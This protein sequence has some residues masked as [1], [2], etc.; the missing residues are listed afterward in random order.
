M[1]NFWGYSRTLCLRSKFRAKIFAQGVWEA[2]VS[3]FDV[4]VGNTGTLVD[5]PPP[6]DLLR[7]V[8]RCST[9]ALLV[10]G[11]S[12]G[13]SGM[14]GS[15]SKPLADSARNVMAKRVDAAKAAVDVSSIPPTPSPLFNKKISVHYTPEDPNAE[16]KDDYY[17]I[18]PSIVKEM[19]KWSTVTVTTKGAQV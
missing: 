18:D 8:D 13:L 16:V 9:F 17:D 12:I 7:F 2:S 15:K 6:D 5:D 11:R 4:P 3:T 10:A 19:S 14:G 1:L